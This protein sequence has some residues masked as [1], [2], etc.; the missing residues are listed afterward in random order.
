MIPSPVVGAP[1]LVFV[2][3]DM[4]I[5]VDIRS[6]SCSFVDLNTCISGRNLD[7]PRDATFSQHSIRSCTLKRLLDGV[8]SGVSVNRKL[9]GF[10]ICSFSFLRV[11]CAALEV[12]RKD[13]KA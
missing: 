7:E 3:F 9:F 4:Q 11:L 6:G 2:S 13:K 8:L 1:N 12:E 10:K 5:I